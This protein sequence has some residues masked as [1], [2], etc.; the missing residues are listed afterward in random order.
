VNT[1][2][3][4]SVGAVLAEMHMQD[5]KWGE[6]TVHPN[7]TGPD[8]GFT[9]RLADAMR[10]RAQ[11]AFS[12]GSGSWMLILQEEFYEAMAETS[13]KLLKKELIQVAAVALAWWVALNRKRA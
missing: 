9:P 11:K 4:T 13:P 6:R 12:Q 3:Y 7:G 8:F 1:E 2:K 10:N 5:L